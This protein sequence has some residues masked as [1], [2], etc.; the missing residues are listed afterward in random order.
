MACLNSAPKDTSRKF[1]RSEGLKTSGPLLYTPSSFRVHTVAMEIMGTIHDGARELKMPL[2]TKVWP[3]FSEKISSHFWELKRGRSHC[4]SRTE[5]SKRM[6]YLRQTHPQSFVRTYL[7]IGMMAGSGSCWSLKWVTGR[8]LMIRRL[9]HIIP[10]WIE[11]ADH[12]IRI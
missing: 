6:F 2:K 3:H 11:L 5:P 7:H 10:R 9:G 12:H 4:W 8:I 1:S